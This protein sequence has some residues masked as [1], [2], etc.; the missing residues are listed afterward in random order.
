[1]NGSVVV[2]SSKLYFNWTVVDWNSSVTGKVNIDQS[3]HSISHQMTLLTNHI[4]GYILQYR[5][6]ETNQ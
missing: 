1:M 6:G 2:S 4:T 3:E 5:E